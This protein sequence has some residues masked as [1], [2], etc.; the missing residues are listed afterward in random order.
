MTDRIHC[1]TFAPSPRNAM[2]ETAFIA[3]RKAEGLSIMEAIKAVMTT[4]GVS[5][6][7]AKKMVSEHPAWSLTVAAAGPLHDE[8]DRLKG[9][10]PTRP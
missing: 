2:K 8:L 5:L 9:D 3:G 10:G 4:Y 7:A 6:A 1:Q